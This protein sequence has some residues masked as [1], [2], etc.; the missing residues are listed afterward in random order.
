MPFAIRDSV[1]NLP[2]SATLAAN[3]AAAR[4]R[5]AGARV[6]HMGFGQSP[7]PVHPLLAEALADNAGAN[8]YEHVAGVEELRAGAAHYFAAA[9]SFDADDFDVIVAPGSKLVLYALQMAIAGDVVVPVPSWVSYVPQAALLGDRVIPVQATLS[10]DGYRIDA[11][12]L[13]DT[14]AAAR[15][16]GAQPT[17]LI[18]NTPNNPT[19]LCLAP[20]DAQELATVCK[21]EGLFVI[22]DEIYGLVAFDEP[23]RSIAADYGHVAVTTGLSKH[24]SL[25]GWRVGFGFIPRRVPGLFDALCAIASETWS[26]VSA[27][28]QRAATLAVSGDQRLESYVAQCTR[29]HGAVARRVAGRIRGEQIACPWP[30]GAFY[31]WPDFVPLRRT[32]AAA[33]I[34][35]SPELAAALLAKHDVLA[36]PGTGFGAPPERLCLRLSVCDYDG[37]QALGACAGD[38]NPASV[39]RS[40]APKVL[41]AADA[42]VAFAGSHEAPG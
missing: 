17:K 31:L 23:H 7:F 16:D 36:L 35:T 14:L 30:A 13:A 25:G 1:A 40:F 37:A 24:L 39:V 4:R 18:I 42:I 32:L 3:Q 34:T 27:P 10:D 19:G 9:F 11:A 38:V 6:L 15:A 20:G 22:S 21:S 41:A 29:I 26:S 8:L 33:G 2:M 12:V 5:A 28:V